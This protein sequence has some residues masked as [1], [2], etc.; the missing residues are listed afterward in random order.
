MKKSTLLITP[1]LW[2]AVRYY[3]KRHSN[4]RTKRAA[5]QYID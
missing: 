1:E 5:C 2:E 4:L 3:K